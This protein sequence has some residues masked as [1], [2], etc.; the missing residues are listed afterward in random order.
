MDRLTDERVPEGLPAPELLPFQGAVADFR[1]GRDTPRDYLERAIDRL[2]VWEGRLH[3]FA[4]VG[5]EQA[6]RAADAS[7]ERWRAGRPRSSIDGMPVGVKDVIDTADLP[8]EL[9]LRAYAG[10]RPLVD[11]AAVLGLREAGAV[12]LGKTA[13][14]EFAMT[15]PAAT[16]NPHDLERTPGGSSSG[17][18]AAVGAGILP[19]A[20]GTQ[21]VGSVLRPASYCGAFGYKPTS[22]AINRGGSHDTQSHSVIG[23][24]GASLPDL[25]HTAWEIVSR[26]GGD[27]GKRGLVGAPQL[28]PPSRPS[29]V[30]HLE[31]DGWP[32]ATDEARQQTED[33]LHRLERAGVRVRRRQHDAEVA[34][35]EEILAG[36]LAKARSI[37]NVESRWPLRAVQRIAPGSLSD[38]LA[39]RLA[40]ADQVSA[41]AYQELLDWRRSA[42]RTFAAVMDRADAVVTLAATGAAPIGLTSTGNASPAVPSSVLGTPAL[43]LPVLR[44]AGLPLGL[45]VMGARHRDAAVFGTARWLLAAAA[46]EEPATGSGPA[47]SAGGA[48]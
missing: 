20:L 7:T 12:V 4:A 13:T 45:Q 3:A 24:I 35:L 42:R 8:T 19:A 46:G 1:S 37:I 38:T 27:P 22:G 25:W 28:A 34:Q 9:G 39:A 47:P 40:A 2:A 30:V 11:A 6:R 41:E 21:A 29:V 17:S 31:T 23:V 5:I 10:R 15:H 43:T 48:N 33:L 44:D 26:V 18:A 14:T 32:L 36:A 16:R